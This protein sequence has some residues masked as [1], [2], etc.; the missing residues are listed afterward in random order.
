MWVLQLQEPE[1]HRRNNA[2]VYLAYVY[3]YRKTALLRNDPGHLV[4]AAQAMA[5]LCE[6]H[7]E[8][9]SQHCQ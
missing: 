1:S 9:T 5:D 7:G 6:N 3:V 4:E 2:M 8:A